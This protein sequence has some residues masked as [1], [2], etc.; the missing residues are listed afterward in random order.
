MS[1]VFLPRYWAIIQIVKC[2]HDHWLHRCC[3]I[4]QCN[5]CRCQ[6][7]N[8]YYT[9][10]QKHL[11][12]V[13]QVTKHLQNGREWPLTTNLYFVFKKYMICASNTVLLLVL[14]FWPRGSSTNCD[15]LS[16]LVMV[17]KFMG[18]ELRMKYGKYWL[19][20]ATY[21]STVT[22]VTE[23]YWCYLPLL[24]TFLPPS[25]GLLSL[26]ESEMEKEYEPWHVLSNNLTFW[27]V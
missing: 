20:T 19:L 5:V 16:D 14:W 17:Y 25:S 7:V 3:D 23:I 2:L 12:L 4:C 18:L 1:L 13:S 6:N 8:T 22:Y 27:Q 11:K 24:S 9:Y 26:H 21:Q 10:C 15:L